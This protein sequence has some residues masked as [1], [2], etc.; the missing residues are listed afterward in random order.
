MHY[1]AMYNRPQLIA[2]LIQQVMDINAR[3][4]S[5]C[6]SGGMY[7]IVWLP[8]FECLIAFNWYLHSCIDYYLSK[9]KTS[10]PW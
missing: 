7:F 5:N 1:A 10:W 3:K 9:G 4:T 8:C 6:Q 2:V